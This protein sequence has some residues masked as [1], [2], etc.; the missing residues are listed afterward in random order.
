LVFAG[1]DEFASINIIFDKE[2]RFHVVV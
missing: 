2:Y 1:N